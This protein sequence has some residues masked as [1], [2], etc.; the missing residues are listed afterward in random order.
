[1]FPLQQRSRSVSVCRLQ[2]PRSPKG[3]L[4]AQSSIGIHVKQ[5]RDLMDR[6]R[7][8]ERE[9]AFLLLR[10]KVLSYCCVS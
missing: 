4:T 10:E 7:E 5:I 3:D 1:M 8:R 2:I 6:E 9:S